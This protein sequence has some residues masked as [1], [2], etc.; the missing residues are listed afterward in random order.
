MNPERANR[1]TP[2]SRKGTRPVLVFGGCLMTAPPVGVK[3]RGIEG[4]G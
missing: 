2:R 1:K 4:E 3:E